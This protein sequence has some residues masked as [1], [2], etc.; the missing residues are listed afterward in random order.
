MNLAPRFGGVGVAVVLLRQRQAA[1][2]DI[3]VGLTFLWTVCIFHFSMRHLQNNRHSASKEAE[4]LLLFFDFLAVL[5][6]HGPADLRGIP[7]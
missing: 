7:P 3:L 6:P 2:G 1:C 4:C 5:M